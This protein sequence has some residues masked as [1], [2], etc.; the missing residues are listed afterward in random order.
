MQV[1]VR[2]APWLELALNLLAELAEIGFMIDEEIT[3]RTVDEA[4]SI[5]FDRDP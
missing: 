2:T 5:E 4:I 1:R 3:D